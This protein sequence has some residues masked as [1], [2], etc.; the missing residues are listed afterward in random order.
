ML[1]ALTTISAP[2]PLVRTSAPWA[3]VLTRFSSPNAQRRLHTPSTA[4]PSTCT[5]GQPSLRLYRGGGAGSQRR[6]SPLCIVQQWPPALG[7]VRTSVTSP[8]QWHARQ[9]RDTFVKQRAQDGYRSRA[10]Y[11]LEGI[12]KRF[13]LMKRGMNVLDLGGC[14]GGWA[15]VA[16]KF[17]GG[18]GRGRKPSEN[19][20]KEGDTATETAH[21]SKTGK[22]V[23]IDLLPTDPIAGV[24]II[25]GDMTDPKVLA[26]IHSII[27]PT[28][29][30]TSLKTPAFD[31][32]L[33]DMA[34]PFTGS[35]TADVLRVISLCELALSVAES[36]GVLKSGGAFVCKF[37]QGS[38]D[39][40]LKALLETRF[41]KVAYEKPEASRSR[42]AE[43]YLVCLGY[44][45]PAA[46]E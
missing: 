17:V 23:S 41:A 15:Q 40:D 35:R 38:G 3:K 42:S 14:P 6:E 45:R 16:V 11:K 36:E 46:S 5:N 20:E 10:A 32:V 28:E 7:S 22:V 37:I 43:G 39:A 29:T 34:H 2:R 30:P 24:D 26:R 44:R 4:H 25:Q 8:K 1:S 9:S 21:P 13:G 27:N 18:G 33:S 12:Q 19:L 31:V